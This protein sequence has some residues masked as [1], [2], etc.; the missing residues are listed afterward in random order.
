MYP[1][2][3]IGETGRGEGTAWEGSES[4]RLVDT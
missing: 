2:D 1:E 4:N 3:G